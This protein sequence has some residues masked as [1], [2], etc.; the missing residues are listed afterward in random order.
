MY[1]TVL[2]LFQGFQ[3][4]LHTAHCN[5]SRNYS[6]ETVDFSLAVCHRNSRE[7]QTF[8]CINQMR[9]YNVQFAS[10]TRNPEM[11]VL[12]AYLFMLISLNSPDET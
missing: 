11:T 2:Q 1:R 9:N 10:V 12:F 4:H 3:S 8:K 5:L 7:T 6:I